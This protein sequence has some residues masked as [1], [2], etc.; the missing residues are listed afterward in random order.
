[1]PAFFPRS[2]P[3]PASSLPSRPSDTPLCGEPFAADGAE[4]AVSERDAPAPVLGAAV[5][6]SERLA[7]LQRA[8][9][10]TAPARRLP[11]R[12]RRHQEPVQVAHAQRGRQQL[13]RLAVTRGSGGTERG[14]SGGR[15]R[16]H[17][18]R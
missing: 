10:L 15:Q 18:S 5:A 6:L 2:L 3:P 4:L 7:Q 13:Q 1:M 11:L 16:Q 14:R 12:H 8:L 9:E 17:N